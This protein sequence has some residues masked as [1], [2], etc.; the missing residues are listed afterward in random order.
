[1]FYKRSD[2]AAF[3]EAFFEAVTDWAWWDDALL[4]QALVLASRSGL[5]A[6]DALHAA[7][8]LSLGADEIVTT[9]K[10]GRPIHRVPGI[11]IR[12]LHPD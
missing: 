10:L 2:E 1:M 7:A 4:K 8:A 5:S 12:T 6:L 11:L 9:E 3:Y